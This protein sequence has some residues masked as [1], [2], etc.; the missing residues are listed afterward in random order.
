MNNS[1][2]VFY[3]NDVDFQIKNSQFFNNSAGINGGAIY[4]SI[5]D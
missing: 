1:G 3:L 4:F 2:G 5:T